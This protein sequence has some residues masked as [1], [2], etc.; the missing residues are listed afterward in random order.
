MFSR[1]STTLLSA[2]YE[3]CLGTNEE[4]TTYISLSRFSVASEYSSHTPWAS[5]RYLLT[6]IAKIHTC[7]TVRT[8]LFVNLVYEGRVILTLLF[9]SSQNLIII[10]MLPIPHIFP[11]ISLSLCSTT[12]SFHFLLYSSQTF[13]LLNNNENRYDS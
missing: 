7:R 3:Q 8:F 4:G 13:S 10:F 9:P 1:A 11:F 12:L 2:L 6:L 5:I